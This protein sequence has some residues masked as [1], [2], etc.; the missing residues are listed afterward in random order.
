MLF[1]FPNMCLFM[2][3]DSGKVIADVL[4]RKNALAVKSVAQVV[5]ESAAADL[6]FYQ[7]D[8]V[9]SGCEFARVDNYLVRRGIA[10]KYVGVRVH[11]AGY[12]P[13]KGT[14]HA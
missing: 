10:Q 4:R 1:Y 2:R 9:D 12:L 7:S 13:K 3:T 14:R 6:D 5:G 8:V 11:L